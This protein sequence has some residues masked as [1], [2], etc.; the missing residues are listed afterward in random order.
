MAV[1]SAMSVSVSTIAIR[2]KALLSAIGAQGCWND[3]L[4]P[5]E[6]PEAR[7]TEYHQDSKNYRLPLTFGQIKCHRIGINCKT[8][9]FRVCANKHQKA[10]P[11]GRAFTYL[12]SPP[13]AVTTFC[14]HPSPL[15]ISWRNLFENAVT[16]LNAS[17]E[18]EHKHQEHIRLVQ[19][20][21]I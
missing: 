17:N 19:S 21:I 12:L 20:A 3:W 8:H 6:V 18:F 9:L 1:P 5:I 15:S 4:K 7:R 13:K 10:P 16:W 11:I 2:A 14:F